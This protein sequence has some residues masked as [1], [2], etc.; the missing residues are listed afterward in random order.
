[1]SEATH[2]RPAGSAGADARDDWDEASVVPLVS[3]VVPTRNEEGNVAPLCR[4][5]RPCCRAKRSRSCSS[6][7]PTT[8]PRPRCA[9]WPATRRARSASSTG[10]RTTAAAGS[11]ARSS[12]AC[13]RARRVG[14]RHGR[15]PPASAGGRSSACSTARGRAGVDLVVASRFCGGGDVGEL[16]AGMPHVAVAGVLPRSR[17]LLFPRPAAR[18]LGPDERLLPRAP[19]RARPRL[20]AAAGVQDPARDPRPDAGLRVARGAVRVRRAAVAARARPSIAR[21]SATSASSGACAAGRT[22]RALRRASGSS[23]VTGLVVNTRRCSRCSPT[24][25]G[26]GTTASPRSSPRRWST[27]WN[28]VLTER[29]VFRG[30]RAPARARGAAR[31][32][33]FAMNNVGAARC[34]CRCSCVLVDRPRGPLPRRERPVARGA[35]ARALRARRHL[36]LARAARTRAAALLDYDIHGIVTVASDVRLP[37]LEHFRVEELVAR[38]RTSGPDRPAGAPAASARRAAAIARLRLRRGARRPRLRRRDRRS[39]SRIEV[40]RLAAAAPLAARPLHERRRADP[41]LDVR[42]P[43]TRWCT[44]PASP[45]ASARS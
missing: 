14:V 25:S 15:R 27:L 38:P 31:R 32:S 43:A 26:S 11:V 20:A 4:P 40:A 13:G 21:R 10:T 1:M 18:G 33:F 8:A 44:P 5:A 17:E 19:R 39:A 42:E 9:A 45:T 24:C 41:A 28:F 34:G 12:R 3:V 30:A 35:H 22:R 7:T 16:R 36:D 29:W 6:T 37:E 23:G 2:T